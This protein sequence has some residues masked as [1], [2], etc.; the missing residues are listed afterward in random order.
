[1]RRGV[2]DRTWFAAT[3]GLALALALGACGGGSSSGAAGG[4]PSD[5]SKDAFCK[6]FTELGADVTPKEAADRLSRVGTPRG[7][8]SDQRHGFEVL[9]DNLRKLPDK[10]NDSTLTQMAKGLQAGDKADVVAFL[11]YY[12]DECQG[13]PSD[14]SS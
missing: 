8:G 1:M 7:I 2:R 9:L 11:T 12:A 10:A 13:I 5:A 14:S 4:S 6:T 3:T